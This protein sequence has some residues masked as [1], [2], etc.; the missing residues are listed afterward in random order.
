M[1]VKFIGIQSSTGCGAVLMPEGSRCDEV[2]DPTFSQNNA[3]RVLV[4]LPPGPFMSTK[5]DSKLPGRLHE[6]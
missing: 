4:T 2:N 1:T 3:A 6:M 5:V